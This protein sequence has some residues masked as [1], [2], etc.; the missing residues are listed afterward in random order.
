[1]N[2]IYIVSI[3]YISNNLLN[4][5]NSCDLFL[6]HCFDTWPH[7][8]P[9]LNIPFRMHLCMR[10]CMIFKLYTPIPNDVQRWHI[11]FISNQSI[12]DLLSVRR[13]VF[14]KNSGF[15]FNCQTG[16][17]WHDMTCQ[18]KFPI[19]IFILLISFQSNI[20]TRTY[21]TI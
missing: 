4:R 3:R 16:M 9:L 20:W 12:V 14:E 8:A 7:L 6:K 13:F 10:W 11:R 18:W 21:F 2:F 1:M 17:T 5:S 15:C 19:N